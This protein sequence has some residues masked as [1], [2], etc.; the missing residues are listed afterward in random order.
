MARKDS[1]LEQRGADITKGH[2]QGVLDLGAPGAELGDNDELLDARHRR[3][4]VLGC[5]RNVAVARLM[6]VPIRLA[7]RAGDG[8]G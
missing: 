5:K 2:A 7:C 1:L 8:V 6:V 4:L 3:G